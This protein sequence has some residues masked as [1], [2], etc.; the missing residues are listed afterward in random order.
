[1]LKHETDDLVKLSILDSYL[2]QVR[3]TIYRQTLFAEFELAMHRHIEEGKTL[4]SDWLTEQYLD[5]TRA[6]YGHG[7]GVMRVDDYIGNEW[8]N[9]PHFYLNFY[10]FQYSTGMIASLALSDMVLHGGKPELERYLTMLK[11]GGSDSPLTILKNAGVDMTSPA[12]GRAALQR[13]D[14]L[15]GE[16]EKIVARLKT[17]GRI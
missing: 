6:Y 1:M 17:Q 15:V 11:S 3:G 4:T 7:K 9:V 13:F 8:S 5:V 2:D 10:V 12:P 16:M 14:T